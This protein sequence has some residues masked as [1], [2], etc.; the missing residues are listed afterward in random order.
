MPRS[1]RWR[2]SMGA[3][4][5]G[6][7]NEAGAIMPRSGARAHARTRA[8]DPSFN[9]AGAIMPRSGCHTPRVKGKRLGF[10]EAGAIMPRSGP[11]RDSRL[12]RPL[13][14]FNEA[15]AIMPRSGVAEGH[16]EAAPERSASMRPGQSCPGVG[17]LDLIAFTEDRRASMRP[18]QSCPGVDGGGRSLGHQDGDCFNE[19]GAIMPR[20][21]RGQW[22]RYGVARELQ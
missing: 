3:P 2:D 13:D 16:V 9:E 19:A 6:C 21:G 5:I 4:R 14:R 11:R 1:G 20:S 8:R 17:P 22:Q 10:N 12:P 7:F 18:G 15:G